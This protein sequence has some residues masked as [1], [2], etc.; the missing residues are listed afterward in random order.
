MWLVRLGLLDEPRLDETRPFTMTEWP[1]ILQS[2]YK[3]EGDKLV[4]TMSQKDGKV[5]TI[6]RQVQDNQLVA[7]RLASLLLLPHQS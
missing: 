6:T 3:L 7:V 2:M 5:S 4:Q 1:Y